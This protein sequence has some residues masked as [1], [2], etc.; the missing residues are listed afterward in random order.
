M[1][2]TKSFT[3]KLLLITIVSV[4]FVSCDIKRTKEIKAE[5]ETLKT[6]SINI[7]YTQVEKYIGRTI[8][9]IEATDTMSEYKL[10]V[11]KDAREC[12]SCA[13]KNMYYWDMFLDSLKPYDD[14]CKVAFVFSPERDHI[15]DLKKVVMHSKFQYPIYIDTCN[16]F[17]RL[18]P[19]I[20]DNPLLH[21]FLIDG[22][23]SVILVGNVLDNPRINEL[24]FEV[25][26]KYKNR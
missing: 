26:K 24:F 4:A 8:S 15:K 17:K 12:A 25:L 11:Y 9:P 20:P 21:T 16:L 7:P 6:Q 1:V 18:N 10:I 22:R 5:I 23:D 14:I 13:L 19:H 2:G 3:V